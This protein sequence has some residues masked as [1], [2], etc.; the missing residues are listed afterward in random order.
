VLE[1]I[2]SISVMSTLV[3][4]VEDDWS[5]SVSVGVGNKVTDAT[6]SETEVMMTGLV[7]TVSEPSR[8]LVVL[9]MTS[10][11]F[12][13]AMDE[14]VT[15]GKATSVGVVK[16]SSVILGATASGPVGSSCVGG[17]DIESG[18]LVGTDR[19][20]LAAEVEVISIL[21]VTDNGDGLKMLVVS[22]DPEPTPKLIDTLA[23]GI[24]FV[25]ASDDVRDGEST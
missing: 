7:V 5:S 19:S 23:V 21:S 4:I 22:S 2:V 24:I 14:V 9:P 20:I 10:V 25:T 13:S 17:T 12:S 1:T 3:E 6:S 15:A 8:M 11:R 16:L 18:I